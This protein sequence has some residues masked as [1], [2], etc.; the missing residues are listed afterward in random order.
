MQ[1]ILVGDGAVISIIWGIV[2]L[3][4]TLAEVAWHLPEGPSTYRRGRVI[5]F[6]VLR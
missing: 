6:R 2:P 1:T 4:P 3:V 5:D